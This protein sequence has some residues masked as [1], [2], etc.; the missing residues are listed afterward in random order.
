MT[1]LGAIHV[2]LMAAALAIGTGLLGAAKG[3]PRH[4]AWGRGFA[5]AVLVSN[6]LVF[7]IH[8]DSA[9]LGVF[10]LLAVVSF[11]SVLAAVVLVRRRKGGLGPRI[12]HGHVM[13]WSFGGMVAAGL[14]QGA[15]L[16]GQPPWPAIFATFLVVGL[17]AAKLD[18][19]A[20]LTGR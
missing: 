14:G 9:T 16:L 11:A 2:L 8:E 6:I 10:H 17:L 20:M 12:G 15:T 13:L 1:W 4:R 18:F 19:K 3:T 7:A 5:A